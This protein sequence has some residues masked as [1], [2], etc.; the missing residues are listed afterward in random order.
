MG[1]ILTMGPP[2][3]TALLEVKFQLMFFFQNWTLKKLNDSEALET[4][5]STRNSFILLSCIVFFV[6]KN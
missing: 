2:M 4:T 6:V 5:I 1:L 3:W